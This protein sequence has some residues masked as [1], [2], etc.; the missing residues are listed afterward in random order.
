VFCSGEMDASTVITTKTNTSTTVGKSNDHQ[1]MLCTLSASS[2][3]PDIA[4]ALLLPVPVATM[5]I[6][7]NGSS[8]DTML[9]IRDAQCTADIACDD[10]GGTFPQSM[11]TLTNMQPGAY[12]L[13]VDGYST[14]SGTTT[15]T[16]QGTVG[17]GTDCSSAL[18]TGGGNAVLLCPSGTTC[19]GSPKTCQ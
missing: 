11:L 13:V 10:D 1:P 8:F 17:P 4:Y 16:V 3:A 9:Y 14:N 7:T 6:D 12:A 19:T 18:F 5:T 2:N 15:L